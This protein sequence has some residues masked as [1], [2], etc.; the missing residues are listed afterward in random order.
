MIKDCLI[1]NMWIDNKT[2]KLYWP[3]RR[4]R[5]KPGAP[6]RTGSCRSRWAA[7]G[8]LRSRAAR[9]RLRAAATAGCATPCIPPPLQFRCLR[10]RLP[11][12]DPGGSVTPARWTTYR[13]CG[14]TTTQRSRSAPRSATTCPSMPHRTWAL[15]RPRT[16]TNPTS[17]NSW[18]V[19]KLARRV[20]L[21]IKKGT[22][23]PQAGCTSLLNSK[24][25]TNY[26]TYNINYLIDFLNCFSWSSNKFNFNNNK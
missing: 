17:R 26:S 25:S 6:V 8:G 9:T 12:T 5:T 7:R 1:I 3:Q 15:A 20:A 11:A 4:S 16:P 23:R 18:T 10:R 21:L 24:C 14:N 13:T 19:G 2:S 22:C